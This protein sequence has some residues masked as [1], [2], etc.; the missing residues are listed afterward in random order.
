MKKYLLLET[1]A[2]HIG[3]WKKRRYKI[4]TVSKMSKMSINF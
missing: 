2:K 4:S 1:I 3:F